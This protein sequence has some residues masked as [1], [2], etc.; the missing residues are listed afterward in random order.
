MEEDQEKMAFITPMGLY[1]FLQMPL[2]LNNTPATFQQLMELCLGDVNQECLLIYLDDII[3]FLAT[4]K[5]HLQES[6]A[7]AKNAGRAQF[8]A[9]TAQMSSVQRK[10]RVPR[11]LGRWYTAHGFEISTGLVEMSTSGLRFRKYSP[12]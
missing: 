4:F 2:K 8:E 1:E 5:E 3:I 9:E 11:P 7:G 6:R 12:G 10:H